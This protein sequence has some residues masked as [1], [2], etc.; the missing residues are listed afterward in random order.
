MLNRF[1]PRKETVKAPFWL[2]HHVPEQHDRCTH[3]GSTLV[4]RRCLSTYPIALFVMALSLVGVHWPVNYDAVLLWVMPAPA[5]ADFVAE[6]FGVVKYNSRRQ[7]VLSAIGAIAF[8]RG[9]GRY[10]RLPSDHLFWTVSV[11]YS[12][13]MVGSVAINLYRTNSNDRAKRQRES[14]DWWAG[15]EKNLDAQSSAGKLSRFE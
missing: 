4:C 8:G 3:V 2:T 12:L 13:V 1:R 14:D 15:V 9:L 6:H 11:V 7:V 10:L 5:I